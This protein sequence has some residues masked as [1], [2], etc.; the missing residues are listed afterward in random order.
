MGANLPCDRGLIATDN[1]L[2]DGDVD[3]LHEESN[4]AHHHHASARGEGDADEL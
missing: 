1:D 4:E 3:K 2:V